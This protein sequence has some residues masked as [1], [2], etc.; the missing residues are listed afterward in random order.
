MLSE[1]VKSYTKGVGPFMCQQN[2]H[3]LENKCA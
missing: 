1:I 3:S 2:E